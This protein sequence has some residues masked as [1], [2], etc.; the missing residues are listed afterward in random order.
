MV[1]W[2]TRI[3]VYAMIESGN[4][5]IAKKWTIFL[6]TFSLLSIQ[7]ARIYRY[8]MRGQENNVRRDDSLKYHNFIA[9]VSWYFIYA[10]VNELG[11]W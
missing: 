5:T 10:C 9:Y 6:L 2:L 4:V 8:F 3:S 11:T 7:P 1:Q